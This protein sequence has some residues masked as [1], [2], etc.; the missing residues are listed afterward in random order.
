MPKQTFFNLPES[1]RQAFLEVAIE[2][3]AQNDY[4][5]A[6]VSHIVA[7]LGIAKGSVY[8]YFEDKR[9]LYLYL[10]DLAVQERMT[11]VKNTPPPIPALPF[12]D[13]LQWLLEQG[14]RFSLVHPRLNQILFRAMF[15]DTPF[16]DEAISR[17]RDNL[18]D[19]TRQLLNQGIAS[20]DV[21]PN[22]DLDLVSYLLS[23]MSSDVGGFI[24]THLGIEPQRLMEGDTSQLDIGA[25]REFFA[26]TIH[27]LRY[28]LANRTSQ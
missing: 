20:G 6:S 28:G 1:K 21:D 16:R 2:E 5:S 3:F 14:V 15:G 9:D 19:Y 10:L 7:H 8:Q 4:N 26:R 25:L 13:Y 23:L 18:L 24:I 12:F 17:A 27:F 11:F 22:I